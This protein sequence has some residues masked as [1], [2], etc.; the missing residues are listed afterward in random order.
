ML[1]YYMVPSLRDG[2]TL[3]G[4]VCGQAYALDRNEDSV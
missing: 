4:R 2:V 3:A 1:Y